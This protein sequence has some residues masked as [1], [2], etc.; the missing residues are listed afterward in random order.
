MIVDMKTIA[1]PNRLGFGFVAAFF[2]L[3]CAAAARP[4]R[5]VGMPFAPRREE[6]A[7]L[8]RPKAIAVETPDKTIDAWIKADRL[9]KK[10]AARPQ[11]ADRVVVRRLYLD[12]IGLLPEPE[13]VAKFEADRSPDKIEK[14]VDALLNDSRGYAEHWMTFWSDL[15]RNDEQTSI[16]G[17]RKPI[18]RWLFAAL[19]DNM[20]YDQMV[21]ELLDPGPNGPDGFLRGV[22]WRGRVN[23]SQRPPLQAAQNVAQVFLATSIRCALLSRRLHHPLETR[24][25]LRARLVLHRPTVG[26]RPMREADRQVRRSQVSLRRT[27]RSL[28]DRRLADPARAVARMVTRPKTSALRA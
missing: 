19:R 17:L 4:N 20:P 23:L 6:F 1:R 14:L 9:A 24:R 3:P 26:T 18:S 15:L 28:A 7:S 2:L 5:G 12:T 27:R 8:P 11:A 21:T 13:T 25:F 22:L 10:I 16:D